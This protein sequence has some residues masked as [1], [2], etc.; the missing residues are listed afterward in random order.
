MILRHHISA[1]LLLVAAACATATQRTYVA[2]TQETIVSTTEQHEADP[3]SH[4]IYIENH[5]TVPVTVFSLNL[6][7]CENIKNECGA[8]PSRLKV[9]P[10]GR[11]LAVRIEPRD[12]MRRWDYA[13]GFS[14]HVDSA[15][16]ALTALAQ[17]GDSGSRV[18]LAAI[19][20]EDSIRRA[21]GGAYINE[22][23]RTDFAALRGRVAALRAV[24]ESL[25]MVPGTRVDI[26]QIKIVLV[27]SLGNVLGRTRW[28]RWSAPGMGA[29]QFSPPSELVAR[30]PGRATIRFALAD[31]AQNL[32]GTSLGELSYTIVAAY[33]PDPHAPVFEGRAVDADTKTPLACLR[34]ALEDSAQNVVARDRTGSGGTFVL[35]APRAGTY[36]VRL[37]T[38]GWAPLYGPTQLAGPDATKQ[39]QY[40]VRFDEQMLT[41]R[42]L[43]IE[44]DFEH[45]QP[46]SIARTA[47]SK[48]VQRVSFGGSEMMPVLTI[49]GSA[50]AGSLWAEFAVDSTG[51]VDSTSVLLPTSTNAR[52]AVAV[53]SML[54]K[55]HF[56]PARDTGKPVCELVR[57]QVNFSP[58]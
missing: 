58:R 41:T 32:L 8:H 42:L 49:V 34:A 48:L 50:P 38:F 1:F 27:D 5:S 14:W 40:S 20:R 28:R 44:D 43:R 39:Q 4:S 53:R 26:D 3:P 30:H 52:Q 31:E 46:M 23:S 11:T 15:G 45:A 21:E 33:P 36:R 7:Q 56:T 6:T 35:P 16:A 51:R 18:R 54:P 17:A 24:P 37:E 29:V 25:V 12:P 9:Q 22:L 10:G 47:G 55:I 13:F 2:P 19:Q 57:L